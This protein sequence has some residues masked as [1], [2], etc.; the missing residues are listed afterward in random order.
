MKT[1]HFIQVRKRIVSKRIWNR[2]LLS[3]GALLGVLALG[4]EVAEANLSG[5]GSDSEAQQ[6][7]AERPERSRW[8]SIRDRLS[9]NYN[10]F[11]EGPGPGLPLTETPSYTGDPD[12]TGLNFFNLVSVRYQVSDRLGLDVQFRN[13]WVLTNG[14]EFRHQG[15]RF[16]LSGRLLEGK[17][18]DLTGAI[19]TD[20][21]IRPI[22]GQIASERTLLLNP[23][24]FAN[25]TYA[26]SG[27]RWSLFALLQP[28]IWFYQDD[29]AVSRQDVARNPANPAAGKPSYVISINPSANYALSER[30][31]IRAGTTL[32]YSKFVGMERAQRGFLPLELGFTYEASSVLNIYTYVLTSTPLDDGLR[33]DMGVARRVPWYDTASLNLWLSGRLF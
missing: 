5:S 21:P 32:E 22:M 12:D 11:F 9:A 29:Q 14:M 8:R 30:T 26:P 31:G 20:L 3:I 23:G 17:N 13:Q 2:S 25:F 24:L 1:P 4:P 19:N 27:S 18:W 15:Q 7:V 10:S 28:R 16:G 6:S 33:R